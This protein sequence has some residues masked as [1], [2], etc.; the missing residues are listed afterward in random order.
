MIHRT[1]TNQ[2]TYS[3]QPLVTAVLICWNHEPFVRVSVLGALQQTYPN[4]QLIV[5][6]NGS[7]DGSRR[8]L[9]KV[10]NEHDFTLVCQ[11]NIGL[12]RALNKGLAMAEGKYFAMLSTDDIWLPDKTERQVAFLEA[13]PDVH[14]LSGLM[15]PI[16]E[17]GEY[18]N[19]PLTSRPG[20]VTFSDLMRKGCNVTGPTVMCRT[21]TLRHVGGYDESVRIEDYTM[22]LRFSHDG[23]RIVNRDEVYTLYRRHPKQWT[24]RPYYSERL[25]IGQRYRGR[26][27]YTAFVRHNLHGYFRWL[28]SE[29]KRDAL[30]LL[31]KEPIAWKWND[32]GVGML[33]LVVPSALLR[34][35]RRILHNKQRFS[36]GL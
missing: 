30:R 29:R 35:R 18:I 12:V 31:M 24:N 8:E 2:P 36:G 22:A 34:W 21:E 17:N 25:E 20:E 27:E 28:A 23:Y 11:E 13:N 9:E 3:A 10:A 7:T 19:F 26:S 6:D 32:V 15:Q 5:F 1:R 33:R 14:M 16:D 4:I